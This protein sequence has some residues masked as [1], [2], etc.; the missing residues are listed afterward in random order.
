MRTYTLHPGGAEEWMRLAEAGAALRLRANPAW[1]GMF[2][3]DSGGVLNRVVHLYTYASIEERSARRRHALKI[4][5]LAS[6]PFSSAHAYTPALRSALGADAEWQAHVRQLR[7]LMAQTESELL[8]QADACLTAVGAP[9]AAAYSSPVGAPAGLYELRSYSLS[10]GYATVPALLKAFVAGLPAKQQALEAD[11]GGGGGHL[12]LVASSEVGRLNRVHELWRFADAGACLAAR[13][14]ARAVP[15]WQQCI[16][17]VA[18][19][20]VTFSTEFLVP[21]SFS[22]WR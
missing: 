11:S 7:P 12:V 3:C 18:P 14:A 21:V 6:T 15:A 17:S 9:D 10:L 8:V 4:Q 22:P 2:T 5:P 13:K 20:V 1:R 16:A 19:S